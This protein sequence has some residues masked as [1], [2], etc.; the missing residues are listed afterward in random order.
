M[1]DLETK[2]LIVM[3][4][5]CKPI[6]LAKQTG[7]RTKEEIKQREAAEEAMKTN[8]GFQPNEEVKNDKEALKAFDRIKDLLGRIDKDDA[9]IEKI[10]NR[11]CMLHSECKQLNKMKKDIEKEIKKTKDAEFK[12]QLYRQYDKL[13]ASVMKKY[14]TMFDIEKENL[15]TLAA[16]LRS[17]PKKVVDEEEVDPM[18][19][20]LKMVK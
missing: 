3:P 17:I 12:M 16:Q 9:L 1:G 2:E 7:H 20:F 8:E 6:A 14:K 5:P 18:A 4:T 15:M 10:L 19:G 11:Y 13:D